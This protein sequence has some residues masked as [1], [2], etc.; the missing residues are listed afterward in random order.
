[1]P[2][3]LDAQLLLGDSLQP[4]R[5][6]AHHAIELASAHA[7]E[8]GCWE[9]LM[10][11]HTL[12]EAG[13]GAIRQRRHERDGGLP[14]VLRRLADETLRR[15]PARASTAEINTPTTTTHEVHEM[16]AATS[17]RALL[18]PTRAGAPA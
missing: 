2:R 17:H 5:E 13:N 18:T 12:V 15:P 8:L 11:L 1:V 16:T 4:A 6:L 10:R 7:A 14:L 3:R 9:E